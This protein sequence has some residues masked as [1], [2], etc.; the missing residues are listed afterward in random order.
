[1]TYVESSSVWVQAKPQQRKGSDITI[2]AGIV[3]EILVGEG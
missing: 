1:M 2:K 3:L